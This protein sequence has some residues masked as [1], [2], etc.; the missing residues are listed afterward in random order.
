M[1]S[2]T[3]SRR[4]ELVLWCRSA[5]QRGSDDIGQ[6]GGH[7][8]TRPVSAAEIHFVKSR[9]EHGRNAAQCGF[10]SYPRQTADSFGTAPDKHANHKIKNLVPVHVHPRSM[11]HCDC[12]CFNFFSRNNARFIR[13]IQQ[14]GGDSQ[15]ICVT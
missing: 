1:A 5:E 13:L 11:H 7:R 6:Q 4:A 10:R 8:S 9:L 15:S 3:Y 12:L 2:S 14:K